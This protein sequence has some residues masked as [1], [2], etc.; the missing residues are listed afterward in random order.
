MIT[1][2]T[3][4]TYLPIRTGELKRGLLPTPPNTPSPPA[5]PSSD[6]WLEGER[7]E[8]SKDGSFSSL[9]WVWRGGMGLDGGVWKVS[10]LV[11]VPM[12]EGEVEPRRLSEDVAGEAEREEPEEQTDTLIDTVKVAI[13]CSWI[14]AHRWVGGLAHT[15]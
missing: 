4:V 10:F 12:G 6:L 11:S 5:S 14:G 9:P 15:V 8:R 3:T 7:E 1:T 2:V 13:I